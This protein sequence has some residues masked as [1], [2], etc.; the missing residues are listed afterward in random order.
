MRPL[1]QILARAA[2]S[3]STTLTCDECFVALEYLADMIDAGADPRVVWQAAQR[4]LTRCPEC[5]EHH[6]QRIRELESQ[7]VKR[8]KAADDR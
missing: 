8:S 1:W 6:L 2:H 4:H 3:P 5:R 7:L